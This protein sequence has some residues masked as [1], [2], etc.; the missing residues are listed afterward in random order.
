MSSRLVGA[1]APTHRDSVLGLLCNI[2][3]RRRFHGKRTWILKVLVKI[4][5][6]RGDIQRRE[7]GPG[8]IAIKNVSSRNGEPMRTINV[9][10]SALTLF[11]F[12][13]ISPIPS[14]MGQIYKWVDDE[15]T[16]HMT[17]NPGNIPEKYRNQAQ[18]RTFDTPSE[19][20]VEQ[21]WKDGRG[22]TKTIRASQNLKHF[23]ISYEAFEGSARRIIIP[24]TLNGTVTADLL[25]D[26]GSPGLLLSPKLADRLGLI[27]EEDGNLIVMAGGIGG[28]VPAML[29]VVDTIN[30]GEATSEFIPAIITD[31]ESGSYEGLVGMDFLSDYKIN[32]DTDREIVI[33]NEL[34]PREDRPGGHD[35]AWW[36]SNFQNFSKLKADW[37]EAMKSLKT[38]ELTSSESDRL[39]RVVK[40]QYEEAEKICRKLERYARESAA[41]SNW[42]R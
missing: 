21:E 37:G 24:V 28:T 20:E 1:E 42:R 31:V 16:V 23:E 40:S 18:K 14:S 33:F 34:P 2:N 32:I 15:G 36:R 7:I 29:A 11:L 9:G 12:L 26:T 39:L 27:K 6:E 22:N 4:W 19:P 8:F 25:L 35:E 30:V 17:D 5:A 3:G 10:L 41:P 38:A 13:F